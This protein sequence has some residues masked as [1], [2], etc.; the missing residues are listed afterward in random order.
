MQFSQNQNQ[1]TRSK[2]S[3]NHCKTL[4]KECK[5]YSSVKRQ[6][7]RHVSTPSFEVFRTSRSLLASEESERSQAGEA[8]NFSS[9]LR[10]QELLPNFPSLGCQCFALLYKFTKCI[11]L[12]P[13][14][15]LHTPVE[16]LPDFLRVPPQRLQ[17]CCKGRSQ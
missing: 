4:A 2:R 3:R 17:A 15:H 14:K 8:R 5:R 16:S 1:E 6:S 13:G 11:I 7:S 9:N 12:M 10:L